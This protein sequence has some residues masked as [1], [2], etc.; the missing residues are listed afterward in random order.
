MRMRQPITPARVLE[1][2]P[3][4]SDPDIENEDTVAP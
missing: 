2:A 4:V 1:E 3:V